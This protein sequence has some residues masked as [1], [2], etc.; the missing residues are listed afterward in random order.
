LPMSSRAK[1]EAVELPGS[2][3]WMQSHPMH[4]DY[5]IRSHAS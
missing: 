2:G 4:N 1:A 5:T 3:F